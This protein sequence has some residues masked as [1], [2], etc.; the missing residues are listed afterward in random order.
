MNDMNSD[1]PETDAFAAKYEALKVAGCDLWKL[2]RKLERE[3][4]EV[5]Q[6]LDES[7]KD[8]CELSNALGEKNKP[9]EQP[10]ERIRD[11]VAK[12]GQQGDEIDQLRT[13]VADLDKDKERLDWFDQYLTGNHGEKYWRVWQDQHGHDLRQAI[14]AARKGQR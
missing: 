1:T 2:A 6:E 10:L 11:M 12:L 7:A 9:F 14:D 8:W 4:D 5:R 3:R 13:R